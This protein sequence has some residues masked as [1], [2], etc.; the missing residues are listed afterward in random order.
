MLKSSLRMSSSVSA[1]NTTGGLPNARRSERFT[2]QPMGSEGTFRIHDPVSRGNGTVPFCTSRHA[3][4]S[5]E[6]LPRHDQRLEAGDHVEQLLV[7]AT[8]ALTMERV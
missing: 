3:A 7:D 5:R 4:I 1:G 8:L 2:R 6:R